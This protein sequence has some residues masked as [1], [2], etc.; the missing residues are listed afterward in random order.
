MGALFLSNQHRS[1]IETLLRVIHQGRPVVA[2]VGEPG[3]GKSALLHGALARLRETGVRVAQFDAPVRFGPLYEA[4]RGLAAGGRSVLAIDAAEV[5]PPRMLRYLGLKAKRAL[6]AGRAV[7]VVLI[8]RPELADALARAEIAALAGAAPV[9]LSLAPFTSEEAVRY[10]EHRVMLSGYPTRQVMT[11]RALRIIAQGSNGLPAQANRLLEVAVGEAA[12]QSR[13]WITAAVAREAR[14]KEDPRRGDRFGAFGPTLRNAALAGVAAAAIWFGYEALVPETAGPPQLAPVAPGSSPP[15]GIGATAAAS[16][17]QRASDGVA[18]AE[19]PSGS[20]TAA[21]APWVEPE[22]NTA[23]GVAAGRPAPT[24]ARPPQAVPGPGAGRRGIRPAGVTRTAG[25]GWSGWSGHA[26]RR[27]CIRRVGR[28]WRPGGSSGRIGGGMPDAPSRSAGPPVPPAEV[29]APVPASAGAPAAAIAAQSGPPADNA[30]RSEIVRQTAS[31]AP[32]ASAAAAFVAAPSATAPQ[33][34]AGTS[35]TE[36][37]SAPANPSVAGTPDDT[38]SHPA[39]PGTRSRSDRHTGRGRNR[40]AGPGRGARAGY[41]SQGLARDI[42]RPLGPRAGR[43]RPG[44]DPAAGR[45]RRDPGCPAGRLGVQPD[46]ATNRVAGPHGSA[47][48]GPRHSRPARAGRFTQPAAD[49]SG[50]TAVLLAA[51]A[52]P[53]TVAAAAASAMP[54]SQVAKL[55]EALIATLI[56]RGEAMRGTGDISAARLLFDR[57]GEAGSASAAAESGRL[58][59]PAYLARFGAV[60]VAADPPL[61]ATWYRRAAALGDPEAAKLLQR[62]E[63]ATR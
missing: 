42:P 39:G 35:G 47:A 59:D 8:G 54:A 55:P 52:L 53:A 40:R 45:R 31:A 4:F 30:D 15:Q 21:I 36:A 16:G 26:R 37:G 51:N 32:V 34:A 58:R 18:P 12:Q 33:S 3:L 60:G 11:A 17:E 9:V 23:G 14:A 63:E 29:A 13:E 49:R 48:A 62:L 43:D 50:T 56:R 24:Q 5:L 41:D 10:V 46:A 2:L 19:A 7:S 22:S 38:A 57:A 25:R 20:A 1:T 61:A 6:A 28:R 27:G 44:E